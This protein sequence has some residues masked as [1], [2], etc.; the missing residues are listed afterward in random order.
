[1]KKFFIILLALLSFT[2]LSHAEVADKI[3]LKLSEKTEKEICKALL[4]DKKNLIWSETKD[5]RTRKELGWQTKGNQ[6]AVEVYAQ[7]P[8]EQSFEETL[9]PLFQKCGAHFVK[10]NAPL[11]SLRI[12]QFDSGVQKGFF[13]GKEKAQSRLVF[14]IENGKQTRS[15]EVGFEIES[16]KFRKNGLKQ[17]QQSLSELFERTVEQVFLSDQLKGI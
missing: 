6:S 4:W 5:E 10:E 14:K 12:V 8:L 15:A 3:N 9:K 7:K 16:K 17:L 1:M 13:T 11:L 2:S